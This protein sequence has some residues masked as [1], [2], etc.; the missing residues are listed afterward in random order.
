MVSDF[1]FNGISKVSAKD[2]EI[3]PFQK[4]TKVSKKR[5]EFGNCLSFDYG[6]PSMDSELRY[7]IGNNIF[8][9][10]D[11]ADCPFSK[12]HAD[13]SESETD[14]KDQPVTTLL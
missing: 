10:K 6:L 14:S 11:A 9:Q 8:V 7:G 12:P 1:K 5:A 2:D 3:R 4:H 13:I